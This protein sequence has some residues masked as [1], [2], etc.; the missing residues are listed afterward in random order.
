MAEPHL[1]DFGLQVGDKT[2]WTL[3]PAGQLDEALFAALS[4]QAKH[5]LGEFNAQGLANMAWAFAQVGQL[6]EALF[7]L[8]LIHI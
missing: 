5:R 6:D 4:K 7:A 3:V 8:S 1:L 2:A